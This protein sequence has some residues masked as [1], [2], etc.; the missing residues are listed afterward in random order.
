MSEAPEIS[1]DPALDVLPSLQ[2][3]GACFDRRNTPLDF[4]FPSG[5]GL[6]I[7]GTVQARQELGHDLGAGADVEAQG[8]R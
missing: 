3:H 7:V 2:F 6:R 4:G 8:F 5:L 1:L